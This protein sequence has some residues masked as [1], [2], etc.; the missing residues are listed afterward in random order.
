MPGWEEEEEEVKGEEE[1]E[2]VEEE[3]EEEE[4]EAKVCFGRLL[5]NGANRWQKWSM[6]MEM[7]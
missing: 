5:L 2:E 4:E 6:E 1:E 7:G 3:E